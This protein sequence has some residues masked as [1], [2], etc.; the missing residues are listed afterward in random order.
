MSLDYVHWYKKARKLGF[1]NDLIPCN[2]NSVVVL[3]NQIEKLRKRKKCG[4]SRTNKI[5]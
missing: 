5:N 2:I 1:E 3:I 4:S